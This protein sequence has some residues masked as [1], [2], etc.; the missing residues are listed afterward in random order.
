MKRFYL[1]RHAQSEAN[2]A[3]VHGGPHHSLSEEGRRQAQ[4]VAERCAKLPLEALACSDFI[5]AKETAEIIAQRIGLKAKV[6]PDLGEVLMPSH[7]M[8]RPYSTPEAIAEEE[9]LIESMGGPKVHDAESF[10]EMIARASRVLDA[11]ATLPEQ[12]VG[13]VTHGLFLRCLIGRALFGP[14]VT[15]RELLALW[16]GLKSEN[17]GLTIL[18]YRPDTPKRL[19]RLFV[20]NDHAH[21]G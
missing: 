13:V 7:M 17:T 1:V 20:W 21:L 5:R 12:H 10:E 3:R 4:F 9:A 19:W 16:R 11:F 6:V 8:E 15:P 18:E 14:E 2:V